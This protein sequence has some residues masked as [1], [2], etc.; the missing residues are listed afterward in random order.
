[1]SK[2]NSTHTIQVGSHTTFD[3]EFEKEIGQVDTRVVFNDDI[4][5]SG[6]EKSDFI[7]DL[8]ELLQKYFI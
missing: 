3:L 8:E 1:M 6:D 4:W 5:I 7:N 2:V